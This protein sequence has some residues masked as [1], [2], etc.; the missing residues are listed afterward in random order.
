MRRKI[1]EI[2]AF[3]VK[4]SRGVP[5]IFCEMML[6][7]GEIVSASVPSGTSIS[8]YEADELRDEDGGVDRAI[9]NITTCIV[10][11]LRGREPDITAIDAL[12]CSL[13]RNENKS[14]LGSNALLAVSIANARA[15]AL[16]LNVELFYL[17][18]KLIGAPSMRIPLLLANV[19]NGGLHT[20]GGLAVQEFLVMVQP[21]PSI[22]HAQV[23]IERVYASVGLSLNASCG[24]VELGLEGGWAPFCQNMPLSRE[25]E[26]YI[27]TLMNS[28]I[29]R[30][31]VPLHLALDVA[32]SNWFDLALKQYS[33]DGVPTSPAELLMRYRL[34]V[35]NFPILALE[36]PYAQDDWEWWSILT[37]ELENKALVVG[38]DVCATRSARIKEA[39]ARHAAH[40]V[41]IKPNQ[42]GTVSETI[43]AIV[44]AQ[45]CGLRVII[46]HRSGETNDTFI[47]DLAVGAGAWG[48]KC[49]VPVQPERRTKYM[50]LAE[51]ETILRADDHVPCF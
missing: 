32:A 31:D 25:R 28:I 38:D 34:W 16:S 48:F 51:I 14:N 41:V 9:Y 42:V 15:H 40:A 6:N 29:K 36:D 13:D 50:R 35:D 18:K 2:R 7:T 12:L 46:S 10:D 5:T 17:L 30:E 43:D 23:L 49:G 21:K 4:D 47:A 3:P 45:R 39:H 27:L 24:P 8:A 19:I 33:W 22:H 20:R 26:E 44:T 1:K 37:A 11:A